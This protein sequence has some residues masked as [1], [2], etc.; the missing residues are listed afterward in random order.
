MTYRT[1]FQGQIWHSSPIF[2]DTFQIIKSRLK[3][4]YT[5][6]LTQCFYEQLVHILYIFFYESDFFFFDNFIKDQ[7]VCM[8]DHPLLYT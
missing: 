4:D 2:Y 3:Q 8:C 7:D 5:Q 6:L 1:F